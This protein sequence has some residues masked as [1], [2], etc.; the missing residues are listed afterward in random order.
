MEPLILASGSPRR[1]QL[2]TQFGIPFE[3]YPSPVEEPHPD[4]HE[5]PGDHAVR[6]AITKVMSVVPVFSGR[7]FILG[8]DTI[9]TQDNRILGKPVSDNDA[10]RMLNHLSGREHCVITGIALI[11]P[12]INKPVAAGVSTRVR[13]RDLTPDEIEWYIAT[14]ECRDKAGA[15]GIQGSGGALIH[16]ITGC[17]YNV[18]GLPVPRLISL[19]QTYIPELWPP[20]PNSHIPKIP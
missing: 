19:L 8:A 4:P 11:T 3:K 17:Y 18:V 15:Y 20:Q 6:S 16:E 13:F 14:G 12:E 10:R 2:L 9:V 7:R 5:D 1:A